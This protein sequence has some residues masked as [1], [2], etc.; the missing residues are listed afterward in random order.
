MTSATGS[1]ICFVTTSTS[2]SVG[3]RGCQ[4][5]QAGRRPRQEAGRLKGGEEWAS[6]AF[7]EGGAAGRARCK[8]KRP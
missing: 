1:A 5:D 3:V 4:R 2:Y 6:S 7:V 8:R